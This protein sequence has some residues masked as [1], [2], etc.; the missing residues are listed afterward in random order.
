ML[1]AKIEQ[2]EKTLLTLI[3][4]ISADTKL[5]RE[6]V[7]KIETTVKAAD[8]KAEKA[9][10]RAITDTPEDRK[11]AAETKAETKVE[12]KA[13]AQLPPEVEQARATAAE[14]IGGAVSEEDRAARK[15]RVR[16][17]L[18]KLKADGLGSLTP[19]QAAK[20]VKSL[21][22]EM[23]KIEEARAAAEAAAAA[24]G[25]EDDDLL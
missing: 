12:T 20:V 13:E 19:E 16:E 11:P 7:G 17:M 1:E 9:A 15:N 24:K 3:E 5:R 14:F 6:V 10:G 21:K 2:L 25:A 8:A 22:A 18:T 23:V 4:V